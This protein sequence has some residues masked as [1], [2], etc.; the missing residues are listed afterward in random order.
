[1]MLNIF[2]CVCCHL[3]VFFGK[4]SIQV[5]FSLLG[6]LFRVFWWGSCMIS[7]F[8]NIGDEFK[9]LL[10][11]EFP[12]SPVVRTRCFQCHDPGSVSGWGTK[13]PQ[14]EWFGQKTNKKS[15]GHNLVL[16]L[17]ICNLWSPPSLPALH[18]T[19]DKAEAQRGLVTF[20]GLHR[21]LLGKPWVQEACLVLLA[22]DSRFV[23]WA[24]G[25]NKQFSN[26]SHVSL[27]CTDMRFTN[28]S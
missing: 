3:Y 8:L 21:S 7:Q 2:S 28:T 13:I 9:T 17:P 25:L 19:D 26:A 20:P 18:F 15:C 24:Q 11:Q 10:V 14:A 23:G 22:Q 6:R 27:V 4:M 1:M 12:G 5:L 16:K